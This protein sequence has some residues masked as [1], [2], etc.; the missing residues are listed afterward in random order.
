MKK[1]DVE[2][3][4]DYLHKRI[5][6][7]DIA[8]K[9]FEQQA[10]RTTFWYAVQWGGESAYIATYVAHLATNT[11]TALNKNKDPGFLGRYATN[12]VLRISR[13]GP[14]R[15]TSMW[16]NITRQTEAQYWA[17]LCDVLGLRPTL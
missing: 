13:H 5:K 6:E 11:L 10:K 7:G 14:A 15:S 1:A 3:L 8:R 17:E 9:E 12:E 16:E 4:K 2:Q